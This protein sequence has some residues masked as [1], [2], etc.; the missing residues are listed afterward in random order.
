MLGLDE[1]RQRSLYDSGEYLR[2]SPDWSD[3][4][5]ASKARTAVALFQRAGIT[6]IASILDVGCGAGGVIDGIA[7]LMP[8]VKFALGIDT[9]P[10]AIRLGRQLRADSLVDLECKSL[11]EIDGSFDLIIASHVVEHVAN[12]GAFIDELAKR[13]GLVYINIPIEINAFYSIRGLSQSMTYAK[14][15]HIN[16]FSEMFFKDFVKSRGYEIVA[17]GYGTE[18]RSQARVGIFSYLVY[19]M[20][21]FAGLAFGRSFAMRML[22]GF[23]YQILIRK[24]QLEGGSAVR[25]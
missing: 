18:F 9:A 21:E 22:G 4:E 8:G 7:K 1:E 24:K 6:E 11:D 25:D 16:F 3:G 12:Y 2:H 17:E 13:G 20:R 15:G 19:F 23:T 14:Y 10:E 5:A